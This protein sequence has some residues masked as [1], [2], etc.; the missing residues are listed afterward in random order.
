MNEYR[1]KVAA[2]SLAVD[3]VA[4]A[5]PRVSKDAYRRLLADAEEARIK[6][7]QARLAM[8]KHIAEHG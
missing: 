3:I 5:R 8:E 6:A 1:E 2:Y 4:D 7:E